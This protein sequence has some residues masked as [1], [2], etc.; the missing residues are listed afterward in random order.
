MGV[1]NRNGRG[2]EKFTSS[3]GILKLHDI[4]ININF[5]KTFMGR[6]L[7]E[8]LILC[9]AQLGRQ[10]AAILALVV[11]GLIFLYSLA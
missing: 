8:V 6:L 11:P 5:L 2:E 10:V 7:A 1:E 9:M 3:T 4:L